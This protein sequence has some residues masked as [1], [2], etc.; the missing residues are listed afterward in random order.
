MDLKGISQKIREIMTLVPELKEKFNLERNSDG[1]DTLLFT[2]VAKSNI[3]ADL[4]PLVELKFG[5]PYKPAGE[6]A[7]L[8]NW[9]DAFVKDVGG[10]RYEQTLFRLDL[11][12]KIGIYC[13]FWPW[14]SD[15]ERTSVR[16]GVLCPDD[17]AESQLDREVGKLF[18]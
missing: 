18:W 2:G 9:F 7:L 6:S 10:V 12:D 4:T 3:I 14:G 5:K 16:I 11:G 8:K 13:A 17:E 15:P 1:C